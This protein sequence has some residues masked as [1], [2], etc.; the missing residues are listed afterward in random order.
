MMSHW[1]YSLPYSPSRS[2]QRYSPRSVLELSIGPI[3]CQYPSCGERLRR[4]AQD[5]IPQP[6]LCLMGALGGHP[7]VKALL[8]GRA[9]DCQTWGILRVDSLWPFQ[10]RCCY[11]E[12]A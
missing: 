8:D 3:L 9:F 12:G 7:Q 2:V 4:V 1:T 10:Y 11:A 5:G 6:R